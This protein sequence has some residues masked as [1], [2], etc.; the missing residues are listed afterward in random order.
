MQHFFSELIESHPWDRVLVLKRNEFLKTRGTLDTNVYYIQSGS[1]KMCLED[2]A[3]EHILRFGYAGNIISALDSYL[4]EKPS[5][6]YIQT[7][8]QSE[9]CI[10]SKERFESYIASS[11]GHTW[12][13]RQI[14]EQLLLQQMERE[15]DILT[16]SPHERYQ[17][18]LERSP[19]LFQHIPHKYIAAYLRMTPETL[20][21]IKKY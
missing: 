11:E 18:V 5:P 14:L 15:Q 9:I 3:D 21:R 19:Q 7:L 1:V 2:N 6:I 16:S 4:T 13:W 8:K 12:Q 17:R 20:S 10:L